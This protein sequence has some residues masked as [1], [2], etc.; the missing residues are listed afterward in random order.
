[1]EQNEQE[2]DK[3][4]RKIRF[5]LK[6]HPFT[7]EEFPARI[8]E[9]LRAH[10]D[11]KEVV[12]YFLDG[13]LLEWL[14]DRYYE[15][16]AAAVQA[17]FDKYS[18]EYKDKDGN[19]EK[20]IR[21]ITDEESLDLQCELCRILKVQ[22][23]SKMKVDVNERNRLNDFQDEMEQLTEDKEALENI[24]YLAD[25]QE[26]FLYLLKKIDKRKERKYYLFVRDKK[27]PP[28]FQV[29]KGKGKFELIGVDAKVTVEFLEDPSK[30]KIS[31]KNIEVRKLYKEEN[32]TENSKSRKS[33]LEKF[34]DNLANSKNNSCNNNEKHKS[35]NVRKMTDRK[36]ENSVK[37]VQD[38]MIRCMDAGFPLILLN[39][40]E[41]DK[42]DDIIQS[43]SYGRQVLEWSVLGLVKKVQKKTHLLKESISLADT[44][45]YF[46]RNEED[47]NRSVF[48]LKDV[49]SLL[50][51]DLIVA[52][53]KYLAQRINEGILDDVNVVIVSQ[54]TIVPPVLEHFMTIIGMGYLSQEEII[55]LIRDFC[56]RQGIDRLEEEL[57]EELAFSFKGLSEFEII[58]ILALAVSGDNE[59]DKTDIQL[60]SEQKRQLIMKVGLLEMV[61][62][63]EDF[64]SIGGLENLK[65]WLKRKA[66]IYKDIRKAR[67]F[68]VDIPK[69]VLITG[70]PG[71]GKSLTAK[72]TAKLLDIP[73]LKMDMGRLMGKYVGESEGNMRRAISLA[74]A[75]APC[76]LWIDELEKVFA[77]INGDGSGA[78]VTTRL[79]GTFLTWL[80]ENKNMVFVVATANNIMKLP[81]ELLRKGRFDEIFYVDLPNEDERRSIL[82]IH[83]AKRRPQDF[84]E[85][86]FDELVDKTIG[87]CGA[88]LEAIVKDGIERAFSAQ[89]K[90]LVEKKLRTRNIVAAI[91]D[92]RSLQQTNG[93]TIERMQK[94]Y[95]DRKFKNATKI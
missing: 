95:K 23:D 33:C 46:M 94:L 49:Q 9:D 31:C 20:R 89:E 17:L 59:I 40:F 81:P 62:V 5:P 92:T 72:A 64:N 16:K 15:K 66:V 47:L 48:V 65:Q 71:C 74:E 28:E 21:E 30:A 57:E 6:M 7:S 27:K 63:N 42:A 51:D 41:E 12:D 79:F 53:L 75:I 58:N 3:L 54:E 90:K 93:E 45:Q 85:I 13:N 84:Y 68:G 38:K 88:D 78:E 14:K 70:M 52:R 77:G 22:W 80:Q 83:V 19:I 36:E 18:E 37:I 43:V 8:I 55:S 73:L 24:E 44:L 39:T 1:M 67:E 32:E 29:P 82:Q 50:R 91:K 61:T 10:Y 56:D 34:L 35:D 26:G 11:H 2:K 69:G 76:V 87:Y 4:N 25:S 86:N 60:I